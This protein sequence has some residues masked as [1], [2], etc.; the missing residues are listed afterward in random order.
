MLSRSCH[1]KKKQ[2]S[3]VRHT[4]PLTILITPPPLQPINIP[5]TPPH[6][7]LQLISPTFWKISDAQRN[8]RNYLIFFSFPSKGNS[9]FLILNCK[10]LKIFLSISDQ[11]LIAD[12]WMKK[13]SIFISVTFL[14]NKIL[15]RYRYTHTFKRKFYDLVR[16]KQLKHIF[17]NA[18]SCSADIVNP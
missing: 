9:D 18:C 7:P 8:V 1:S 15:L 5:T 10:Y 2:R 14:F 13:Q 17:I 12:F 16:Y 11:L 4:N 6:Q 3:F